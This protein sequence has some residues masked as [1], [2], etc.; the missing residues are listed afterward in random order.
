MDS[1]LR[2]NDGIGAGMAFPVRHPREC[3]DPST[4]K[5]AC[6]LYFYVILAN[7]GIHRPSFVVWRRRGWIPAY[8]GMTGLAQE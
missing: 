3:G 8:A 4:G 1:C 5:T 2:R 7:A 6:A